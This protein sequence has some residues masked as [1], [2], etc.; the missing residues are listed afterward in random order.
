MFGSSPTK[1]LF[2]G[3]K[4]RGI[5]L[6][7]ARK[8]AKKTGNIIDREAQTEVKYPEKREKSGTWQKRKGTCETHLEHGNF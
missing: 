5:G 6:P 7:P 4:K 1:Y 8:G 3:E 2:P